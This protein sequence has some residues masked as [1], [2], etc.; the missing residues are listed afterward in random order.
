[1]GCISPERGMDP[2]A[3]DAGDAGRRLGAVITALDGPGFVP[4]LSDWFGACIG[5]DNLTVLVWAGNAPPRCLH[6]SA[7]E[8]SVHASVDE[9]YC[10]GGYLLDPF[11]V[12]DRSEAPAGVYRLCDVAPDQFRSSEYYTSYYRDTKIVDEMVYVLRPASGV[13]IHVC[14]GRDVTSDTLFSDAAYETALR[15]LP[16]VVALAA[17]HWG[18]ITVD[19]VVPESEGG[20]DRSGSGMA[21]ITARFSDRLKTLCGVVLTR[22]QS[23]TA[24]LILRGHSSGSA[25]RMLGVSPQT[26]KVFRKQL[27][28][29][30]AISSQAELFAMMMPILARLS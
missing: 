4:C 6:R 25:A 5:I 14:L 29:R 12:L 27:Y 21:D 7:R 18:H 26:V 17:R 9:I 13:S 19:A 24:L 30:C 23:E 28:A 11:F 3:G 15:L 2:V 1:M 8:E 10:A 20:G 22:R 16:V